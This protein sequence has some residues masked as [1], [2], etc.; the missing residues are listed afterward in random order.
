MRENERERG[1]EREKERELLGFC[2]CRLI[3][4]LL[5]YHLSSLVKAEALQCVRRI[6]MYAC[7]CVWNPSSPHPGRNDGG[8]GIIVAIRGLSVSLF[9]IY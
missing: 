8:G 3:R 7:C 1:R 9:F 5:D 4:I 2:V 6:N